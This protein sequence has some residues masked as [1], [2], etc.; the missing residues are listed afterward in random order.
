MCRVRASR[1][2]ALVL[3]FAGGLLLQ[4]AWAPATQAQSDLASARAVEGI[5]EDL[6]HAV[7]AG[8]QALQRNEP[9]RA[10][11]LLTTV[12]DAQPGY[13][14]TRHGVAAYW[15]GR[16][17]ERQ[18]QQAAA[19]QA[20]IEGQEALAEQGLFDLHLAD[21]YLRAAPTSR[22]GYDRSVAV[23][24]YRQL[25]RRADSALAA[26]ESTIVTRHAAHV[27]LMMTDA[28]RRQITGSALHDTPWTFE[29]GAG[30]ALL[31]WWRRH[32]PA[33]ATAENE[34]I[35]EH[36]SRA[37][38]AQAKYPHPDRSTR[39]DDRG[40]TYVRYGPPYLQREITYNDASFVLDVFRF[41]V[42][43]S[44][45]EFPKNE[46]WTYP[47]IHHSAYYIFV[48]DNDRYYIGTSSDLMPRRLTNTF[49]NSERHL[50]RAVSALAAMEYIFR[51]L[52][53]YHPDFGTLYDK[54]ANYAN[55]QEMNATQY[56]ATGRVPAGT[57]V[58][59]VGA[60]IGQQRF[61]FSSPAF[62]VGMPSQFVQSTS[63][64]QRTLDMQA[65]R[66]RR[67]VMPPQATDLFNDLGSMAIATRTARFLGPN[68]RTRTEVYWGTRTP[69][70][71]L[72]EDDADK[73]SLIKLTAVS[74]NT[75]YTRRGAQNK[76]YSVD[77]A[78]S[79]GGLVVPGVFNVNGMSGTYHLALQ[80]EQY[81]ADVQ[82]DR[83][84][85]N[86]QLRVA[87]QRVD[88]LSALSAAPD[89]LEMSD[90]R[91]MLPN[92]DFLASG[93][94]TEA[95]TP[96]P[97]TEIAADASLVLY[98][99]LYHLGFGSDDQTRY[100]VEYDVK[101]EAKRS[102]IARLFRGNKEDRTT[103]STTYEGEG[104]R[105][106]EH[107]LIDLSEWPDD[108]S[109]TLTVTVRVIDEVTGQ[110]V[111]RAIDFEVTPTEP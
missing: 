12:V 110:Q 3:A 4:V 85:L 89:Q 86:E 45:F 90:L 32:D 83:V 50:N 31:E 52:A 77:A 60:G 64:E 79:E 21:A 97:F 75:D 102:R 74:Y 66:V 18:E 19:R 73:S 107:I 47:Q 38:T 78:L 25:L 67:Q 1:R 103:A 20:W 87:T 24:V 27:A 5:S 71:Q 100:T 13:V 68:G 98:F 84:A 65:R 2:L 111:E 53:L 29:P 51:D 106:Q 33:P 49:S 26:D 6:A 44:S 82:G 91:P 93:A 59:R 61:V 9:A 94:S 11:S 10:E 81:T 42:N 22:T 30:T 39:M 70:L 36:L 108:E 88:T 72:D 56:R 7:A 105:A 48:E 80:W 109:G 96:Y 17:H 63:T 46:I 15:L 101:R 35:E 62:G 43:I 54:I 95:A 37:A 34:R 16:A 76:W 14:S 28:E 23:D 40:E 69:E 8:V 58:R 57:R 55:W 99:E 41:G 104:R 92:D